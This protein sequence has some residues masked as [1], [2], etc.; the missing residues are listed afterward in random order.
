MAFQSSY[1]DCVGQATFIECH[2]K[3]S[4][5]CGGFH[6]YEK[7]NVFVCF[8]VQLE[9]GSFLVKSVNDALKAY[10]FGYIQKENKFKGNKERNTI[11]S[12]SNAEGHNLK[13]S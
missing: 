13:K 5:I 2:S 9:F 6:I 3:H 11:Q 7:Q 10:L 12:L 1:L 8:F 4:K